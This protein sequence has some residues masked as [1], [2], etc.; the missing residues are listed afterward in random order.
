MRVE[1]ST[2]PKPSSES[3]FTRTLRYIAPNAVTGA[4]VVFAVLALQA[5]SRGEFV[6]AAWWSLYST[7]TD[8]LDGVVA[9]LLK[10]SS[11]LGVQLD[12]LADLLNYGMVP[13]TLTYAFFTQRPQFGWATGGMNVLLKVLCAFYVLCTTLRLAR[14]NVSTANPK[15]FF[16]VPSTMAG[17]LVM[18]Y[19]IT[20]GKYGDPAWTAPETYSP[21]RMMGHVRLD[22]LMPYFPWTMLVFG[23]LMVCALR[24]PKVGH[25]GSRWLDRYVVG[26]LLIGYTFG[27]LHLFPEYIVFGGVQYLLIAA[28]LHFFATPPEARER[29]EPLFPTS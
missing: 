13:A 4:S 8:K 9:R 28:Y 19:F 7:L 17:A 24:V 29:P 27:I 22:A 18:A 11:P 12:S 5:V 6:W 3:S 1:D 2:Q 21:W 16:G 15:H 20:L 23:Y 25:A 26:N 10:A 14:F